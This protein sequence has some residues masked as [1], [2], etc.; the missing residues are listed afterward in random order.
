MFEHV[1]F[2]FTQYS[3]P[4]DTELSFSFEVRV[5]DHLSSHCI[6]VFCLL[7]LCQRDRQ[8]YINTVF[9]HTGDVDVSM[10]L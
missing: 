3:F 1:V 7:H 4:V 10:F 8:M 5:N 6:P 9:I 2:C